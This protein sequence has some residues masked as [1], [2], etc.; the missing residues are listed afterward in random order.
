MTEDKQA[1]VLET[2]RNLLARAN[3][4][5]FEAERDACLKKADELM[6]KYTIDAAMLALKDDSN[7]RLV[8]RRD[9]DM[10]WWQDLKGID[11]D[12]KSEI[13]WLWHSCVRHCRVTTPGFAKVFT[14]DSKYQV[15]C[16][17]T[18]N[19]LSYLDL[20]FT[21]L[22][23][24]MFGKLKP[25]YDP[26]MEVGQ[27]VRIGK[28]AGMNWQQIIDWMGV[29]GTPLA[30]NL[31]PPYRKYCQEHGLAQVKSS[32]KQYQWSFVQ[33]F[34]EEIRMRL[35]RMRKDDGPSQETG[36]TAL[37]LRNIEDQARDAMW[38]DFPD[39][40]PH[41]ENCECE[42][43]KRARKRRALAPRTRSVN[44]TAEQ[45]GR[46]AGQDAR[47]VSNDPAL[48]TRKQLT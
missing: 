1:K 25:K 9:M 32:P 47:I 37:V 17:G 3:G 18:E 5:D 22:M 11:Q 24:Q 46:V 8:V 14:I 41:P 33:A 27:A 43:C 12:A 23:L 42:N 26:K 19:D 10:S 44:R 15:P 30:D 34:C 38:D 7:A 35:F 20:L 45:H 48:R 39:L 16:F 29:R 6:T 36:S 4:T 13:Y 21:D 28:E 2:V 40:R 31:L